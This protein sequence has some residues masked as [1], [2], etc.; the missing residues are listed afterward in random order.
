[1]GMCGEGKLCLRDA[2]SLLRSLVYC[3]FP[4]LFIVTGISKSPLHIL[5][6]RCLQISISCYISEINCKKAALSWGRSKKKSHKNNK[7]RPSLKCCDALI[8]DFTS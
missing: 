2:P 8:I 6:K 1:M 3:A 4:N 7:K 5:W